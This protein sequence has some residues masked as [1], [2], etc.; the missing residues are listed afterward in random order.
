MFSHQNIL[1]ICFQ[2]LSELLKTAQNKTILFLK[3]Q[4]IALDIIE[5]LYEKEHKS[6]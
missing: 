3:G 1:W 4:Y 6:L 2:R 5:K